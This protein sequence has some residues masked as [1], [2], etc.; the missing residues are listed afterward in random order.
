MPVQQIFCQCWNNTERKQMTAVWRSWCDKLGLWWSLAIELEDCHFI[1]CEPWKYQDSNKL[2]CWLQSR[3]KYIGR[4]KICD[5]TGDRLFP[6][7]RTCTMKGCKGLGDTSVRRTS[8]VCSNG[9]WNENL[10]GCAFW[11]G[12]KTFIAFTGNNGAAVTSWPVICCR[13]NILHTILWLYSICSLSWTQ[14]LHSSMSKA[15]TVVIVVVC[16]HTI[17]KFLYA[18]IKVLCETVILKILMIKYTWSKTRK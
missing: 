1:H 10:A 15:T 5:I 16:D 18:K 13:L 2:H 12:D 17:Q 3:N 14:P 4:I 6:A 7:D 9:C 11:D 8:K